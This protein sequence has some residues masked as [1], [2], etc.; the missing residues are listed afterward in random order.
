MDNVKGQLIDEPK[1][2]TY[3]QTSY[4]NSVFDHEVVCLNDEKVWTSGIGSVIRLYNLHGEVLDSIDIRS[5]EMPEKIAVTKDG[6]LVYVDV[7]DKAVNMVK[8][9]QTETVIRRQ[10]MESNQ[11]MQYFLW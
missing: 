10:W 2:I 11:C 5:G 3:I 1:I 4:D 7:K 6:D 8:N 9:R